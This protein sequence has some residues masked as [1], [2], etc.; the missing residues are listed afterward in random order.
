VLPAHGQSVQQYILST[1]P[2][3]WLCVDAVGTQT[4]PAVIWLADPLALQAKECWASQFAGPLADS[5]YLVRYDLRGL[6][7]SSKP[8]HAEDYS[9][10]AQA[11][12]LQE[13]VR[14]F[15][16]EQVAIVAAGWAGAILAEYLRRFVHEP[17]NLVGLVLLGAI[18]HVNRLWRSLAYGGL[19]FRSHA[20]ATQNEG[21]RCSALEEY[22]RYG[23][24]PGNPPQDRWQRMVEAALAVPPQVVRTLLDAYQASAQAE[25]SAEET[26]LP[27]PILIC[28]G[29]EDRLVSMKCANIAAS[30]FPITRV[31]HYPRL[32]HGLADEWWPS[33]DI[34]AFLDSVV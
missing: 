26:G 14:A 34:R 20:L 17:H 22:L 18:T 3:I 6:G 19:E 30:Q 8:E 4:H 27:V 10:A 13:I 1:E 33:Q 15:G 21:V 5:F 16:R 28:H 23:Y 7:C 24:L 29:E 25:A 32:G 11:R 12:D 2:D 31:I 9:L